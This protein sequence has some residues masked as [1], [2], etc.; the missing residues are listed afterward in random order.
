M[1]VYQA[2]TETTA[3]QLARWRRRA[4]AESTRVR[5]WTIHLG[6]ALAAT[7]GALVVCLLEVVA[8]RSMVP[9][10]AE[11]LAVMVPF[12]AWCIYSVKRREA[13][14]DAARERERAEHDARIRSLREVLSSTDER[15]ERL[16]KLIEEV[17]RRDTFAEGWEARD[18]LEAPVI[19][20]EP[21]VRILRPARVGR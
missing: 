1:T 21:T 16:E 4:A 8:G 10:T 9:Q 15:L 18:T 13:K 11:N 14:D 20:A 6:L 19:D 12:V 2:R 17:R 7:S 3:D 5:P